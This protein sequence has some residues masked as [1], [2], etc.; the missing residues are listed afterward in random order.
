MLSRCSILV[1]YIQLIN[2]QTPKFFTDHGFF[3]SDSCPFSVCTRCGVGQYKSGCLGVDAGHCADCTGLPLNAVWKTEGGFSDACTFECKPAYTLTGRSC[4]IK[5][6][7]IYTVVISIALPLTAVQVN[8]KKDSIITSFAA[9]AD[10]GTC[11]SLTAD[12]VVCQRCKLFVTVLQTAARRL[13]AP[14]STVSVTIEQL[15]GSSQATTTAAALTVTNINTQFAIASVP[16]CAVISSATVD[17]KPA[18][19]TPPSPTPSPP[20]PT[21]S[22]SSGMSVG[23]I[24]GTVSAV[25]VVLVG[26]AIGACVFIMKGGTSQ[27]TAD[28]KDKSHVASP[29]THTE[30]M[31]RLESTTDIRIPARAVLVVGRRIPGHMSH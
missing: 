16:N 23:A 26:A 10:C 11:G 25:V 15:S 8:A 21:P 17:A 24:I 29:Y 18:T 30:K 28:A 22:P 5:P 4:V 7:S 20:S 3:T 19:V 31:M 14:T 13:L 6:D 12:P 27:K 1:L 2:C 9:L